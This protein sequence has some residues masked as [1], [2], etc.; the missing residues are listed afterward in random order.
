MRGRASGVCGKHMERVWWRS[1]SG[2]RNKEWIVSTASTERR[3]THMCII[4]KERELAFLV[5]TVSCSF[6][7]HNFAKAIVMLL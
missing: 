3:A 1:C 2:I 7:M 4:I 5:P 6:G